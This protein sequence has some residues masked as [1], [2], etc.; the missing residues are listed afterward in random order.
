MLLSAAFEHPGLW[1]SKENLELIKSKVNA[2]QEPWKSA[3]E[4]LDADS[5]SNPYYGYQVFE[6]TNCGFYNDPN[7]GCNR[8]VGD[9]KVAYTCALRWY[10]SGD[11]EYAERAI[12]IIDAWSTTY[13]RSIGDNAR[14][15][16]A[17]AAPWWA[18]AAEILR[19]EYPGW[20]TTNTN[21]I[22]AM[23]DRFDD[24]LGWPNA[25]F[26]N[27]N[28]PGNNWYMS[29]IQ[30]EMAIAV[31]RDKQWLFDDAVADWKQRIKT[32]IYQSSDGST[33]IP[34][35]G[36]TSSWTVNL[37]KSGRN[38]TAFIDG[39]CMETCRDIPHTVLGLDSLV[40]A[41]E[42]AWTQGIDLFSLEKERLKDCF[43]LHTDWMTGGYVPSDICDGYLDATT[44]ANAAFELIY[45]HL[46][47]RLGMN[48]P[49]TADII[50]QYRPRGIG[51]WVPIW[52]TLAYANRPFASTGDSATVAA[53][54]DIYTQ[55]GT[56][57]D[58]TELKVE[59]ASRSRISYLRFQLGEYKGSI[60]GATLKLKETNTES[61]SGT[62]RVYAGSNPWWSE[63]NTN[64]LPS[65]GAELGSFSGS[66]SAAQ[67]IT[68]N[69]DS[70]Q[71][72]A[73][74]HDSSGELTLIIDMDTGGNDI[75]FH[76]RQGSTAPILELSL[77]QSEPTIAHVDDQQ[78]GN[79]ASNILDGNTDDSSRWSTQ[80]FP[81]SVIIDYGSTQRITGTR[82]WTY[83]DRAYQFEVFTSD[84][85]NGPWTRIVNRLGN[86]STGQ[87]IANNISENFA[88]YV[89][90]TVSS[91]HNNSSS[92]ISIT[93]FDIVGNN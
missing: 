56:P 65:K 27:D 8:I 10:V 17:W 76:S 83:Q 87:P 72:N 73:A 29:S 59:N 75:A 85:E 93:E 38:N 55:N 42:I 46:H 37:W 26:P 52:E 69:L 3:Y 66:I 39:L 5:A 63:G 79:P 64:S 30:A 20:T 28:R 80:Y 33:P 35:P 23:L 57:F 86:S 48:L 60:T 21:N 31:F 1:H 62:F 12:E 53:N 90:L 45:N 91:L 71:L 2:N 67:T 78:T 81:K 92:W 4:A 22:N 19:Y 13:L 89:K 68:F 9:A 40:Y 61:G 11:V 50:Q 24:Y 51:G 84:S 88:R 25:K 7:I 32:Y 58:T 49:N 18:N 43:E 70:N 34:P 54:Q 82:L 15:N 14:L 16:V 41:A 44:N 6:E 77:G 74:I 36:E 47:D